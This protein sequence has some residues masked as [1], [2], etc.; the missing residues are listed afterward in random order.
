[1]RKIVFAALFCALFAL[2]GAALAEDNP[3]LPKVGT[4]I[5][6]TPFGQ[7]QDA[8]FVNLLAR[9]AKIDTVY[10]L[11]IFAKDVDWSKYKTLFVV[12]GGSGKG[13]GSAGLD[14]PGEVERCNDLMAEAKKH[15]VAIVALHIGG[16]DRRGPNSEPF[17][18]YAGDAD[19]SIV[20]RDGDEDGYFAKLCGEKKV[21]LYYIEKT[22]ELKDVL[23][24]MAKAD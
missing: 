24:G 2:A 4:P 11:H 17:L 19:F 5:L 18:G 14:I 13:L 16:S 6:I 21:P 20:R 15:N 7:S 10:D 1:M 8:N 22:N 12:L 9:R 3:E 23:P